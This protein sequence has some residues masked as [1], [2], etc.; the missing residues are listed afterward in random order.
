MANKFKAPYNYQKENNFRL[1]QALT[2]IIY[3]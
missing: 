1:K 3:N 2:I